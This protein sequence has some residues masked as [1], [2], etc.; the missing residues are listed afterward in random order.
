M[1]D[2]RRVLDW[3]TGF[4]DTLYIQIVT[5]INYSAIAIPTLYSSLLHILL[6]SVLTTR[7]L[8]TDS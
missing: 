2:C 5:T 8:A 3:M 6:S 4:T 1:R 7:I